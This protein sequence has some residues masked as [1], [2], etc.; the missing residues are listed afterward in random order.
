MIKTLI[1]IL[2]LILLLSMGYYLLVLDDSSLQTS[3]EAVIT[4]ARLETEV[5]LRRLNDIQDVVLD[6]EMLSDGRFI[7]RVDY[8]APVP[9]V[10]VGRENPFI[11]P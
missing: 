9:V 10:P 4:Q 2:G 11:A 1:T 7:N 5:F 8:S 6:T 3:N